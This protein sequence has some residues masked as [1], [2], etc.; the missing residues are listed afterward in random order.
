METHTIE[1]AGIPEELLELLDEQVRQRGGD[2]ASFIRDLIRKE[3]QRNARPAGGDIR[4]HSRMSF[5]EILTPVHEQA[6]ESGMAEEELD[7]LFEEARERVRQ[8]KRAAR[9]R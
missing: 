5:A 6:A 1:V 8:E 3:L 2:R 4:P 9:P 7:R